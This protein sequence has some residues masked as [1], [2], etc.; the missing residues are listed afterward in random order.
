[1]S[2]T[3]LCD[4]RY[5]GLDTRCKSSFLSLALAN[6]Q[7]RNFV[8]IKTIFE[9]QVDA[10]VKDVCRLHQSRGLDHKTYQKIRTQVSGELVNQWRT[11]NRRRRAGR[12]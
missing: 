2:Q 8:T 3:Y 9:H 10:L 6:S 11:G 1:M 5:S 4:S 7:E 12:D